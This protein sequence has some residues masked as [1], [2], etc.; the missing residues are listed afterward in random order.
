MANRQLI[1]NGGGVKFP[2]FVVFLGTMLASGCSSFKT[3]SATQN[4]NEAIAGEEDVNAGVTT[5][6]VRSLETPPDLFSPAYRK[7]TFDRVIRT[8]DKSAA[9]RFIPNYQVEKISVQ[10]N[11]EERWLEIETGDTEAVWYGIQEYLETI[12]MKVAEA[13]KDIGILETEYQP[14]LERVPLDAMTG[15]TRVLNSWRPEIAEGIIDK[16]SVLMESDQ[17][18]NT[19]RVYFRHQMLVD[20][21]S[22][23]TEGGSAGNWAA[24]GSDPYLEAEA[25]Y[26]A[27]VFFGT[28]K[29]DASQQV[30]ATE[31]FKAVVIDADN[32]SDAP[33][34]EK[35][36]EALILTSSIN[37]SWKY[38]NRMVYRYD[39]LVDEKDPVRHYMVV[40]LPKDA[41]KQVSRFNFFEDEPSED[42][43]NVKIILKLTEHNKNHLGEHQTKLKAFAADEVVTLTQDH[44]K[45]IF[46]TLG[47]IPKQNTNQTEQVELN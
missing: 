26:E 42:L 22:S 12:G 34:K 16:Y 6:L 35:V 31:H 38:L 41:P 21:S 25:L 29:D 28:N 1:K 39:W 18:R 2:L 8:T 45:Y 15:L 17:T 47:L 23:A 37:A 4:A 9:F 11:L 46:Q 32:A 10:N 36:L 19:I 14:R 5:K 30:K 13:R 43:S 33:K 40:N 7:E 20:T 24:R 3:S 27:M 44:K